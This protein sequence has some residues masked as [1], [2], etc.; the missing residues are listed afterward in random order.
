MYVPEYGQY[1]VIRTAPIRFIP[2]QANSAGGAGCVEVNI[3]TNLI[4]RRI[5]RSKRVLT[6]GGRTRCPILLSSSLSIDARCCVRGR[7]N[8]FQRFNV[9][10]VKIRCH[11]CWFRTR[12]IDR[13][14][15]VIG[16]EVNTA[17]L[18]KGRYQCRSSVTGDVIWN[19]VG[20]TMRGYVVQN[21]QLAKLATQRL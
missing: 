16:N 2:Y 11:F 18:L 3:V 5:P 7:W 1:R 8:G 9:S 13:G 20:L 10:R 15:H 21:L 6:L 4:R 14:M 19:G 17:P 12:P